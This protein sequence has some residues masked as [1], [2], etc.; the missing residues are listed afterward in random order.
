M[1]RNN[2]MSTGEA[3]LLT[4]GLFLVICFFVSIFGD[5]PECAKAGCDNPVSKDGDYCCLHDSY[6]KRYHKSH[7]TS[8]SY[9]DTT[10]SSSNSNSSSGSYKTGSSGSKYNSSHSYDSYDDGY[11]DVYMDGDYDQD[12]YDRDDDYAS[13]VDDAIEDDWEEGNEGDW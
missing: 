7:G 3:V 5:E 10:I 4:V 2:N 8:S 13:G 9:S 11:D 12:R 1:N 6:A